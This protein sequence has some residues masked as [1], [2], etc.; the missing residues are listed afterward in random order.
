M[1]FANNRQSAS[2]R[3]ESAGLV[4]G[5]FTE[6]RRRKDFICDAALLA[7][8]DYDPDGEAGS[9]NEVMAD[10]SLLTTSR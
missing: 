7:L 4:Q 2:R 10:G 1:N 9:I 3:Q 6:S 8:E 5:D